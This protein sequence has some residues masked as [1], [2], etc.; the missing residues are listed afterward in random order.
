ML[1]VTQ[2]VIEFQ[3]QSYLP[4]DL[5]T[6]E[7]KNNLPD[8]PCRKVNGSEAQE[9]AGIESTLDIQYIIAAGTG[10]PSDFKLMEGTAFDLVGFA[11]QVIEDP[12]SALV[13]SVSYGEGINGGIGGRIA[14]D[15][16]KR[17]NTEFEKF[18][19]VDW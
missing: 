18:V 1:T 12:N 3:S 16:T 15:Y 10:V 5:K 4:T 17:L 7:S 19:S 8:Q 9:S 6:F 11:T 14:V 2:A 13:W